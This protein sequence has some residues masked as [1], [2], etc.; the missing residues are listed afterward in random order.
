MS[1]KS[2]LAC[3]KHF[4]LLKYDQKRII[5]P[6]RPNTFKY[7]SSKCQWFIVKPVFNYTR[8]EKCP[9]WVQDTINQF[10]C[11]GQFSTMPCHFISQMKSQEQKL[12]MLQA[13][14]P[15][16]QSNIESLPCPYFFLLCYSTF[17]PMQKWLV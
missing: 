6:I 11:I 7:G 17:Y 13:Q 3:I 15:I 16:S 10:I 5:W 8:G 1:K 9:I 12:H 14:L 2:G 4:S